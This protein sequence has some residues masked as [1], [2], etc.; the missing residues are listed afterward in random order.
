MKY[1]EIINHIIVALVFSVL[2]LNTVF[3]VPFLVHELKMTKKTSLTN[4]RMV[5][6]CI[7][8]DKKDQTEIMTFFTVP[9]PKYPPTQCALEKGKLY[10]VPIIP[11]ESIDLK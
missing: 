8:T 10:N 1:I 9:D 7:T 4:Y 11:V 3:T 2:V 5:P 6:L